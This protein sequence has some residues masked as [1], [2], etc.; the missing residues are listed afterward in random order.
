MDVRRVG[1]TYTNLGRLGRHNP[2]QPDQSQDE[3]AEVERQA[4]RPQPGPN[5]SAPAKSNGK[6]SPLKKSGLGFSE[7]E[8]LSLD[9]SGQLLTSDWTVHLQDLH[10]LNDIHII[11]PRYV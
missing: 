6:S 5:D 8:A 3:A 1:E 2:F 10:Q 7:A 9:L 11:H 4:P